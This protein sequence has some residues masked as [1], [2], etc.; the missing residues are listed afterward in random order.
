MQRATGGIGVRV[1]VKDLIAVE[2]FLRSLGNAGVL[3]RAVP[4]ASDA[5]CLSGLRQAE[6]SGEARFVG[7]TQLHELGLG[8]T[9]INPWFGVPINPVDAALIPGG[10]SSGAAVVVASDLA[11]I[12][13]GTDTGGSIRIPA[14][15]CGVYG[16]KTSVGRIP[17][18]GVHAVSPTLD[19]VGP[20][21]RDVDSLIRGM[22]LLE[23]GFTAAPT[24]DGVRV[25][26]VQLTADPRIDAA[27]D[28]VL[29]GAELPWDVVSL[30][31]WERAESAN[32]VVVCVEAMRVNR[33]LREGGSGIRW[34]SDTD[35]VFREGM[36]CTV[37]AWD[38]ALATTEW[39]KSQIDAAFLQCDVLAMPT[40]RT[41]V[42]TLDHAEDIYRSRATSPINLAGLPAVAIP[43]P[44]SG[45][46]PASLQLVG[47]PMSEPLLLAVAKLVERSLHS[48]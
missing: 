14:A 10:S 32:R 4:Q 7:T 38:Q 31:G 11:D 5:A 37:E 39:W 13:I 46:G 24:A 34:G 20:L 2:G 47:K 22:Q 26:R 15:C 1:A 17:L 43:I 29:S 9:G 23:P 18:D 8:A 42:P 41:E 19:T 30:D 3:D 33:E 48:H 25:G 12:G 27:V 45:Y 28:A 36:N 35:T 44:W 40:L 6:K 21:A 16:L